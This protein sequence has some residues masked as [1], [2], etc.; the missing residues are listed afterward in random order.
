MIYRVFLEFRG[1]GVGLGLPVECV[2]CSV[3]LL[4]FNIRLGGE[5]REGRGGDGGQAYLGIKNGMIILEL[6]YGLLGGRLHTRERVERDED[7]SVCGS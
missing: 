5:E 6:R 1:G 2:A 7:G 4:A 3:R